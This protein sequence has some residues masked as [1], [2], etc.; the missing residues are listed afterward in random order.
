MTGMTGFIVDQAYLSH[1]IYYNIF[2]YTQG[3][4]HSKPLDR[5]LVT[6][7]YPTASKIRLTGNPREYLHIFEFVAVDP[8]DADLTTGKPASQTSTLQNDDGKYGPANAVDA[9]SA[10]IIHTKKGNADPNP[11]WT[12]D[13]EAPHEVASIAIENRYCGDTNDAQKCLGRLSNATVELLDN[14]DI[15]V[16]SKSLGDTTGVLILN[17][18]FNNCLPTLSPT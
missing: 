4:K 9:D 16:D 13:L 10:S 12:V 6:T 1:D 8:S 11:V 15:V 3:L 2:V 5:S 17:L 14:Q 18:D 7:C